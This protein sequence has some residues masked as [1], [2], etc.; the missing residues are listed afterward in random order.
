L[1]KSG[2]LLFLRWLFWGF[3]RFFLLR[4]PV[5]PAL[6]TGRV[7]GY[8]SCLLLT[9]RRHILFHEYANLFPDSPPREIKRI[10]RGSFVLSA[11]NEVDHMRH[12]TLTAANIGQII[13]IEGLP[14]LDASLS[15]GKGVILAVSHFGSHLQIMPA[16]GFM[17]YDIHQV[18]GEWNPAASKAPNDPISQFLVRRLRSMRI[19]YSGSKLPAKIIAVKQGG[20]PRALL[21][22][23]RNNGILAVAMDG[24]DAG[25]LTGVPFLRYIDY[26]FASGPAN[27]ALRAHAALHPVFV[28]RRQDGRNKVIIEKEIV[29]ELKGSKDET[30][31]WNT[32]RIVAVMEEYIMRHP[33]HYGPELFLMEP[34]RTMKGPDRDAG[35]VGGCACA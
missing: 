27:L 22:C 30:I 18:A 4:L 6:L 2:F 16:L 23:L 14:A 8:I 12:S 19:R 20:Y 21:E 32:G 1:K 26:P 34:G 10:V 28:V 25:T 17:G 7:F 29:L 9:K 11:M 3:A 35:A 5:G 15:R 33:A 13:E 24:K 31:R